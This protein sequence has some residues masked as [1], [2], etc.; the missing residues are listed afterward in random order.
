M[1]QPPGAPPADWKPR[2]D[3]S[4]RAVMQR[5]GKLEVKIEE[6]MDALTD[7]QVEVKH[8]VSWKLL[9]PMLATAALVIIGGAWTLTKGAVA[10][11]KE[12][13]V[14]AEAAAHTDVKMLREE[15]IA[16]KK[17]AEDGL[18]EVQKDVRSLY[19]YLLTGRAQPRLEAKV[20][21]R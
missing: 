18:V 3:D 11:A 5:L 15:V 6:C 21:E 14:R 16:N 12:A 2:S 9:V 8:T 10:E 19:K 17:A 7:L 1:N 13:A 4:T 20:D